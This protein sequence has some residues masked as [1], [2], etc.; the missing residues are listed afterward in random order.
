MSIRSSSEAPSLVWRSATRCEVGELVSNLTEAC[1]RRGARL[2]RTTVFG[3]FFDKRAHDSLPR[4]RYGDPTVGSLASFRVR[5][6][7]KGI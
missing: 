1:S 6:V 4:N 2:F 3:S 5:P 7:H